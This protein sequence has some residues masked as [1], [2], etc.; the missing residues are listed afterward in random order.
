M[1]F[2]LII[3]GPSIFLNMLAMITSKGEEKLFLYVDPWRN[4]YNIQKAQNSYLYLLPTQ[5]EFKIL[6]TIKYLQS[7]LIFEW[8]V[9]VGSQELA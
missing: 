8:V 3:L 4:A 9:I 2:P 1:E 6:R 5:Q 7:I